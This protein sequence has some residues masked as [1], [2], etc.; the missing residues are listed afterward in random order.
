MA[1]TFMGLETARR[2]L[3][4]QQSA[5]YTTG[6]NIANANT[7]G[8]TRQRVNFEQETPYP[9]AG[10]NRPQIPGQ[11]GTGVQAGSVQRVRESFLDD[12]YRSQSSQ[13]GYWESKS[14]AL[15]KL[16]Q[17]MN[18][19]TD[20]GLAST[21]DQFWKSLQDLAVDPQN[22][23]ARS[24]VRQRGIAVAETFNYLSDTLTAEKNNMK[25]EVGVAEKEINSI[26]SQISGIN[27]QIASVEPHGYLPNDLYDERDRLID[28]L[29]SLVTVEVK[30]EKA[31]G[32]ASAISEGRATISLVDKTGAKQ[33]DLVT[34]TGYNNVTVNYG[35]KDDS[36]SSITVGDT[37]I[38]FNNFTSNGKLKSLV[39]SYGYETSDG[40]V[41]GL[42][43]DMM[44]ELDNLAYT[45]AT[46]F[47]KVHSDG[48]GPNEIKNKE[49]QEID[50]F[51]D[52]EGS[53]I[54]DRTGFAGR[55]TISQDITNS[56]DNIATADGSNPSAGALGDASVALK[57]AD[58]INQNYDYGDNQESSNFRNYFESVIGAMAIDAQEANRMLAN[59]TTLQQAVENKRL[60]V[61]SVSLDEE[62][63][64]MI[65]FQ[66]AYNAAA[67]MITVQDEML[68]KIIGMG[69]GG[70]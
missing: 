47:N 16:E 69:V 31:G 57:L 53:A 2:A 32:N 29:S 18:E 49:N 10:M 30:Y 13:L 33:A 50:F 14:N 64:N 23:G 5:L 60:S 46:E 12:Q 1:S 20:S 35:G 36:V 58:I 27:D 56:L 44:T 68:E 28:Q 40:N 9:A 59:S 8:Y 15:S 3:N 52:S 61:S 38:N 37:D 24:V 45:F 42:Y 39:E 41:K 70:R 11:M 67:R 55:I 54:T 22:T 65:Q 26:L 48:M 6:H 25:T 7:L 21:M 17:V 51:A 43:S 62:M 19:P 4:T 63:T 66:Q 34:A